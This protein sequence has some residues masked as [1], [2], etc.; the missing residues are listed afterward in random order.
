V[1][2]VIA[3]LASDFF[4]IN[5]LDDQPSLRYVHTH[6]RSYWKARPAQPTAL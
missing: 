2:D 1:H 6:A 4:R 5:Y 3:A